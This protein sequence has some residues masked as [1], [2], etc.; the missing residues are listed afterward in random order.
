MGTAQSRAP[1]NFHNG[2]ARSVEET[3]S[4]GVPDH[5]QGRRDAGAVAMAGTGLLPAVPDRGAVVHAAAGNCE[6]HQST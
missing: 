2:P 1:Q 6:T 4:P 3:P 5:Q